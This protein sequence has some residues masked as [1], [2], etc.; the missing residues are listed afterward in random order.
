M[1]DLLDCEKVITM[2]LFGAAH[3]EH[4]KTTVGTVIGFLNPSIMPDKDVS[5]V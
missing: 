3:A 2:F 1:S 5:C 4:W